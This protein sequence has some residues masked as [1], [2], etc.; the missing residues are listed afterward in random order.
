[1]RSGPEVNIRSTSQSQS[2][3][4]IGSA[5][6]RKQH[7]DQ[8]IPPHET[9]STPFVCC[10]SKTAQNII[11]T[12]TCPQATGDTHPVDPYSIHAIHWCH[13]CTTRSTGDR[14]D[15]TPIGAQGQ[16]SQ[17]LQQIIPTNPALVRL[18]TGDTTTP[19]P[20]APPGMSTGDIGPAQGT[21]PPDE[22]HAQPDVEH[23]VPL[24]L[25][26]VY[27]PR[28]HDGDDISSSLTQ[29]DCASDGDA[30]DLELDPDKVL[31]KTQDFTSWPFPTLEMGSDTA[32][33]Y[34]AARS[35]AVPNHKGT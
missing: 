29:H 24:F 1:M 17:E 27:Y 16:V 19:H 26:R 6:H 5:E 25:Q 13:Q 2:S 34:D 8:T 23:E 10:S 9:H 12:G 7:G 33:L 30:F 20:S 22:A 15:D 14:H 4:H 11:Q 31:Y 21:R 3:S 35:F 18:S 28:C 32:K